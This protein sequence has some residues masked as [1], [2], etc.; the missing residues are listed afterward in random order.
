M[1]VLG[2]VGVALGFTLTAAWAWR[3]AGGAELR[4][5]LTTSIPSFP[6]VA[7][8]MWTFAL[9][10]A[11]PIGVFLL[12][13]LLLAGAAGVLA[14]AFRKASPREQLGAAAVAGLVAILAP[15][16]AST[17][18]MLF[19]TAPLG[20]LFARHLAG[21]S[22]AGPDSS[23]LGARA[24]N[25]LPNRIAV[26]VVAPAFAI[27]LLSLP[28]TLPARVPSVVASL[29]G[30]LVLVPAIR[31]LGAPARRFMKRSALVIAALYV[32]LGGAAVA[33]VATARGHVNAATRL[34]ASGFGAAESLNTK[35]SAT[36]LD[37]A[38]REL[39]ATHRVLGSPI[40]R[41][42]SLLP[43]AGPNIRAI[44]RV[45]RHAEHVSRQAATLARKSDIDVLRPKKGRVNLASWRGLAVDVNRVREPLGALLASRSAAARN[46]WVVAPVSARLA[47]FS[48]RLD[49]VSSQIEALGHALEQLPTL[50]GGDGPR[51]YLVVLGS[52]AE[53]RGSGGVLG[54]FGEIEAVDGRLELTRLGRISDLETSGL[55][56][57]LRVLDAPADY[58][59][60]YAPFGAAKTWTNMNM[61]PDFPSV[62][63]AMANHYPQ[64]GGKHVDG[65]VALDPVA[66]GAWLRL[67]GPLNV[68][69]WP[70]PL[71]AEN[72][73]TVL[74]HDSYVT[75][76][77][78]RGP[79]RLT[80]LA[81]VARL[82]WQRLIGT[83]FPKPSALGDALGPAVRGRHIQ[84]WLRSSDE[85]SYVASLGLDGAVPNDPGDV[86]GVLLNNATGS[87]ID[88]YLH[89][90]V[91]YDVRYD[92]RTGRVTADATLDLRNDAPASG[93]PDYVIG[94]AVPGTGLPRGWSTV[95][96]SLY[97][98][99]AVTAVERDG[100]ALDV[101][102]GTERGLRVTSIWITIPSGGS[103]RLVAR[104]E[105]LPG[106]R[107]EDGYRLA[108]FTQPGV[109]PEDVAIR[110]SA[111]RGVLR[112]GPGLV[113]AGS[114]GVLVRQGVTG[115]AVVR[116]SAETS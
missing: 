70:V 41:L 74:M 32:V 31:S 4:S 78:Q 68:P 48:S 9:P 113:A 12:D 24:D 38:R 44:E 76:D 22:A 63:Q 33:V 93:L 96:V 47:G 10:T 42:A 59:E 8:V 98:A 11:R 60:R 61:S 6:V 105:G 75:L 50:L 52:P 19:A 112:A 103:V 71:T 85:Q 55:P 21:V 18:A 53:A 3:N 27:A 104:L 116:V 102:R 84:V 95:Y 13:R 109:R 115:D 83:S 39:A 111:R 58:V 80:L 51:R 16:G 87:K 49:H 114:G 66:L 88:W 62:A 67:L 107:S 7:A 14:W 35:A 89:R 64:S 36:T 72:A 17:A 101:E 1:N 86:F 45:V 108:L 57:N 54:N 100:R 37:R 23:G 29:A 15:I 40:V 106:R 110:V 25:D 92:V 2:I 20:A 26:D 94:N 82:V 69:G 56:R 34:T 73:P 97:S 77:A 81:D 30:T 91:S 28:T 65:V 99:V 46:P 5:A 90:S 79:E 43:V